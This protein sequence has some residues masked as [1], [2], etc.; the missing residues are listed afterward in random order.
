MKIERTKKGRPWVLEFKLNE[1]DWNRIGEAILKS[2][3]RNVRGQVTATGLQQKKNAPNTIA[4]KRKKGR[5]SPANS[6]LVDDPK[7]YRFSRGSNY[8]ID[9][10]KE[11]A[12]VFPRDLKVSRYVQKKGYVGWIGVDSRAKRAIVKLFNSFIKRAA[13]RA[14]R[15][16]ETKTKG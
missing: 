3:L 2:F 11:G 12:T 16:K 4:A 15:R 6:S 13:N 8:E 10:D 7:T 1:S 14:K 5:R 9:T